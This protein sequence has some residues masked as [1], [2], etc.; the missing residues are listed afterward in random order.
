MRVP[1]V[2]TVRRFGR[3]L[4][5]RVGGGALI[6]GY[7]RVADEPDDP[8]A[9]AVSPRHFAEQLEVLARHARVLR[10]QDLAR[11]LRQG[12]PVRRAVVLTF[13][14]GYADNLHAA[15]PLLAR[16]G[17]PATLFVASGYLGG[18]FWWEELATL[19]IG[20]SARPGAARRQMLQSIHCQLMTRG[21]EERAERLRQLRDEAGEPGLAPPGGRPLLPD[22]LMRLAAGGLFEV[23]AHTV[24]HPALATLPTAEQ[25]R[26]LRESKRCL[27]ELTGAPVR[28]VSYPNGSAD[29]ATVRLA[30]EAGFSCACGS[31]NNV[32]RPGSDLFHLPRFWVPNVDGERFGRW[33]R[34]WLAV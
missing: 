29:A 30:R 33:L 25:E 24:S 1:G 34:R 15:Q 18:S 4:R 26:E 2:K 17:M 27:E 28:S 16:Q 23:G 10:L 8:F 3:W 12:E 32:A 6:L 21:A 19:A 31:W 11:A 14:D 20:G 7:H 22:E 13:D 5:S 9:L